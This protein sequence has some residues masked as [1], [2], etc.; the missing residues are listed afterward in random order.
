VGKDA[1]L[2][3]LDASPLADIHNTAK[4]RAVVANGRLYDRPAL[5]QILDRS[6]VSPDPTRPSEAVGKTR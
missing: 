1:E 4:I 5:D 2:V 6:T 3:L